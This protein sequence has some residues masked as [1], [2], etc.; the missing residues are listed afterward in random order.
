M[1]FIIEDDCS[2][3]RY[4]F[5]FGIELKEISIQNFTG[6]S[7]DLNS[8]D[9]NIFEIMQNSLVK[10]SKIFQII[11]FSVFL[12]PLEKKTKINFV[13]N[14][15]DKDII[16]V[17]SKSELIDFSIAC[18]KKTS[19]YYIFNKSKIIYVNAYS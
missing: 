3:Q 17:M 9:K 18:E 8:F 2:H 10:C 12:I 15:F 14:Y 19:D 13:T 16:N 11:D 5:F 6:T 7:I 1:T 4:N